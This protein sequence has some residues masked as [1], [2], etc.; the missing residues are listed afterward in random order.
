MPSL[1]REDGQRLPHSISEDDLQVPVEGARLDTGEWADAKGNVHDPGELLA[2]VDGNNRA[3]IAVRLRKDVPVRLVL[4]VTTLRV[5]MMRRHLTHG[6]KRQRQPIRD[7]LMRDP[8]RCYLAFSE[9]CECDHKTV[10][11]C[12]G[13]PHAAAMTNPAVGR[14]TGRP[15]VRFGR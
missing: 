3:G 9:L 13:Q 15:V 7:E 12:R 10:A 1:S 2:V 6:H 8:G 11:R 4:G 14:H 5:N